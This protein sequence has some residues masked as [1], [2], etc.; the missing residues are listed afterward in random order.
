MWESLKA[1]WADD[2]AAIKERW[3]Q[4]MEEP[5]RPPPSRS[6]AGAV[7]KDQAAGRAR[8]G[9]ELVMPTVVEAAG[10]TP[11]AA[12]E[13][14]EKASGTESDGKEG[15]EG[16]KEQEE[17]ELVRRT[18]TTRLL[19]LALAGVFVMQWAPVLQGVAHG[20][21]AVPGRD[22][23]LALALACPPTEV[24]MAWQADAV[25][26]VAGQLGCLFSS[27]MLH[28]GLLSLG[29]SLASLEE[30]AP[31]MD[32]LHGPLI[33]AITYVMAGAGAVLAP[34]L[35]SSAAT[36]IGGIGAALGM[37]AAVAVR[38]W[39]AT[40]ELMPPTPACLACCAAAAVSAVYQPLVGPWGVVGGLLGGA[41][42]GI[43]AYDV[44]YIMRVILAITI[45]SGLLVWNV[46]TWLPKLAY[47]VLLFAGMFVWATIEGF[48][49]A[50]R[51]V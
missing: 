1:D 18:G 6:P 14:Q 44:L 8:D 17:Q 3:R 29:A 15:E 24:T 23:A 41:L 51:G 10:A 7:G 16:A 12:A 43:L 13:G 50:L 27:T 4:F 5:L 48:V 9:L 20:S 22:L 36:S 2:W 32:T 35:A 47:R 30:T 34:M 31:W 46:V 37:E 38:C 39:R 33:L 42:S 49:Q 28:S 11:S 26:L 40:R 19:Q 25:T 21:V 45:L